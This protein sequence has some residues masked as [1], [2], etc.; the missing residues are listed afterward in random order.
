MAPTLASARRDLRVA[1]GER[2]PRRWLDVDLD[3]YINLGCSDIAKLEVL[4]S[5]ATLAIVANQGS[6][7]M[8][9]NCIRVH[10]VDFTPTSSDRSVNLEYRDFHNAQAVQWTTNSAGMPALFTLWGTPGSVKLKLYPAAGF[11][12][13]LYVHYYRLPTYIND[14]DD[15]VYTTPSDTTELDIPA[16]WEQCVI[17]HAEYLALR[18]DRD[19]RWQEAHAQYTEL[20]GAMH[21][22]TRRHT[23]QA[24]EIVGSDGEQFWLYAMGDYD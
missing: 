12:G 15:T 4:Q 16:G 14:D 6:V 7:D 5:T 13:N 20:L 1:L 23:D 22:L 24:G 10:R 3:R 8:P 18:A 9:A 11:A 21:D 2:I 19:P 17:S